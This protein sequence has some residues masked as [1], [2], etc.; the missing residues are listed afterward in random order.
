MSLAL[1][2]ASGEQTDQVIFAENE[3][4][5]A[6]ASGV[7]APRAAGAPRGRGRVIVRAVGKRSELEARNLWPT[8]DAN[9]HPER[10]QSAIGIDVEI[11]VAIKSRVKLFADPQNR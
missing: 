8:V 1:A 3:R 5:R 4:R 9:P 6:A 2:A 10:T 7:A 11:A